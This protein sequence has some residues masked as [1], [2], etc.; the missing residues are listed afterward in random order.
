M[1]WIVR[2]ENPTPARRPMEVPV[3]YHL[4]NGVT[5]SESVAVEVAAF[6]AVEVSFDDFGRPERIARCVDEI[7]TIVSETPTISVR[8]PR[9]AHWP[10]HRDVGAGTGS[11]AA[12][13]RAARATF[14][15]LPCDPSRHVGGYQILAEHSRLRSERTGQVALYSPAGLNLDIDD[16]P[17]SL[18]ALALSGCIDVEEI[19][20][21]LGERA[22]RLRL[23]NVTDTPVVVHIARGVLFESKSWGTQNVTATEEVEIAIGAGET[24]LWQLSTACVNRS[25]APPMAQAM[26]ATALRL[27]DRGGT[28]ADQESVWRVTDGA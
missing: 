21:G 16:H 22:T 28:F 23:H 4:G 14:V 6:A 13:L 2:L 10:L 26:R 8:D 7:D 19:A 9:P 11:R 15:D 18:A 25:L 20:G 27:V 3:G 1:A 12:W 17:R 24:V 5:V